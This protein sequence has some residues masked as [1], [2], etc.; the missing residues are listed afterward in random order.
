MNHFAI[1]LYPLSSNLPHRTVSF[2]L[3]TSPPSVSSMAQL[4][5]FIHHPPHY[6]PLFIP[7]ILYLTT[8]TTQHLNHPAS[9]TLTPIKH[10]SLTVHT[11]RARLFSMILFGYYYFF[12]CIGKMTFTFF[13]MWRFSSGTGE[14]VNWD[15]HVPIQLLILRK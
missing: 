9:L 11:T 3:F 2:I 4:P 1:H 13:C 8:L 15:G 6:G 10:S 5:P 7:F 12:S 14:R